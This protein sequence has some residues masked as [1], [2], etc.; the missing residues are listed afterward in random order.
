[1][2]RLTMSLVLQRIRRWARVHRLEGCGVWAFMEL[3]GATANTKGWN[4]VGDS[5]SMGRWTASV[6]NATNTSNNSLI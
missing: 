5:T 3:R 6:D 4:M 1:M 2:A